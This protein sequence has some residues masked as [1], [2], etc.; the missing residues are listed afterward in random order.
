MV[1]IDMILEW[2]AFSV[3][4]L[5]TYLYG[6]NK[7]LGPIVGACSAILFISWGISAILYGAIAINAG[8]LAI[9]I[10]NLKRAIADV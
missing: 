6:H 2:A 7:F 3:A 10:R 1:E 5:S 4:A 8:F 9:H